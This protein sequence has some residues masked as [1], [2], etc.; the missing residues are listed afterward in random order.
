MGPQVGTV[1]YWLSRV[2]RKVWVVVDTGIFDRVFVPK[3][4]DRHPR[5]LGHTWSGC[6]RKSTKIRVKKS[7]TNHYG[8]SYG[9]LTLP[10]TGNGT[11]TGKL[12]VSILR[13]VQYTPH[14][15]R[16]REMMGFYITLC[17]VHTTQGQ[18]PGNDGFL[19][20]TM[21]STHHTGTGAGNHCF[22]FCLSWSL[23][24]FR[25]RS[26]AVCMSHYRATNY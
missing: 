12:W 26:R 14:K 5:T 17:T 2:G 16:D 19:Y 9:L 23:S 25:Y 11:G 18:G 4:R 22:L 24:L 7:Q 1:F 6:Q 3:S 15:D 8:G 20:Y 13:Y 10:G 21:Y